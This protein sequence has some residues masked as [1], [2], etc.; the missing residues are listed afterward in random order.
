[1]AA[2]KSSLAIDPDR[3]VAVGGATRNQFWMQNKADVLGLPIE[4]PEVE[5][6]VEEELLEGEEELGEPEVIGT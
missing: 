3:L 6:E 4:V 5:E 2:L 1:M